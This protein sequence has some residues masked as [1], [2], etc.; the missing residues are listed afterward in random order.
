MNGAESLIR[1]AVGIGL[2]TCFA[3]PGTTE[4]PLVRAIDEVAGIRA[5]LCLFEG[6]CTGAADGYGRMA[7][8]PALTLLHLGPG[9]ANGI[10][11]LH[12]ARRARSPVVNLIGEHATWHQAA[13]PPL[14][15]DIESLARPVSAWLRRSERADCLADDLCEA[16]AVASRRPGRIASLILPHDLQL[17]PGGEA[18]DSVS[19]ADPPAIDVA[20]F[21]AVLTSLK[22]VNR[23][24]GTARVA[25]LLGARALGERGLRA[26]ARIA[27]ATGVSLLA[28]AFPARWERGQGRPAVRRLPYFPELAVPILAAFPTV[29]LAG[30]PSPVSF[31]GYPGVPS[32]YLRPEQTVLTLAGPEEDVEGALEA[33]AGALAPALEPD[34]G[35]VA[36]K[37]LPSGRLT[38]ETLTATVAAMLPPRAIVM[39][40]GHTSTGAHTAYFQGAAQNR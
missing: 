23:S 10:A 27:S 24:S 12:D 19:I 37:A 15:S 6:V 22:G 31:F 17:G 21:E 29:V 4:V 36:S 9:L 38:G 39:D 40:E 1:A 2:D 11:Y 32:H 16:V 7:E 26:A 8:R 34:L 20:K 3:N 35:P 28:E 25:M 30:A 5:V 18:P 33:L 14:H 13:D